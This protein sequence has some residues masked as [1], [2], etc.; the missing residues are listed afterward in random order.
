MCGAQIR[1]E[2]SCGGCDDTAG[3]GFRFIFCNTLSWKDQVTKQ[4]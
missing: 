3:N 4:Y 2:D 1:F